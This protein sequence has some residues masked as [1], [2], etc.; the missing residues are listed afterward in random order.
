[1]TLLTIDEISDMLQLRRNYV[2]DV[3]VKR[4]GFP[5]PAIGIRKQRWDAAAIVRYLK[6]PPQSSHN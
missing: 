6:N 4:E 5:K 1:M 3:V 2:R